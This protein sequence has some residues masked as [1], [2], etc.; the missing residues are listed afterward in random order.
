MNNERRSRERWDENPPLSIQDLLGIVRRR[1]KYFFVPFVLV[2]SASIL[3]VLRLQPIYRSSGK[4]FVE[5]QQIPQD[6]VR[7]M[8]TGFA[9][10]RI[11]AILQFVMTH[12]NLEAVIAKFGLYKESVESIADKVDW[13]REAAIVETINTGR[14]RSRNAVA[15]EVAFEHEEPE[16][17]QGVAKELVDLF[18]TE[19]A[20][21]RA[22]RAKEATE[23]LTQEMERLRTSMESIG[24]KIA[25]YKKEHYNSLPENLQL[26]A[27]KLNR[28]SERLR[29]VEREQEATLE[30]L[31]FY[32]I[33]LSAVRSG[34]EHNAG[35]NDDFVTPA[36]R[37]MELQNELIS[38]EAAFQPE[39]PDI[40]NLRR[41]IA[42]FQAKIISSGG[43]SDVELALIQ[44]RSELQR[45]RS[46][47]TDKHP[48]VK[49]QRLLIA[50]LENRLAK[51]SGD[52]R[53]VVLGPAERELLAQIRAAEARVKS[54]DEEKSLL[55]KEIESLETRIMRTSQIEQGFLALRRDYENAST[56]YQDVKGKQLE[57]QLAQNLEEEQKAERFT[58]LE[59]P[60]LPESPIR[61]DRRKL[62][63]MCLILSGGVGGG[64]VFL[65][66]WADKSV[67]NPQQV[68]RVLGEPPIVML[69]YIETAEDI[70]R[71]A[72]TRRYLIGSAA[73][74]FVILLVSVHYFYKPLDVL[75]EVLIKKIGLG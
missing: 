27:E 39:H 19:N 46:I 5:S 69:P 53:N 11:Q 43:R 68:A 72:A 66:E 42:A 25:D 2:L 65:L 67:R 33:Q 45:L 15:F 49:T 4:I 29:T 73:G 74:G 54:Y 44:V 62:L 47:Y 13:L 10:E 12:E 9:E 71:R 37:L 50:D 14:R 26:N 23:F 70:S 63:L 3:V 55:Q 59:A 36:E 18:L 17:A 51:L 24:Q 22:L 57:A 7:S 56:K 64:L 60:M 32:Q 58:L 48:D 75:S 28:A 40:M 6:I 16:V 1:W 30:Q 34:A 61:P 31:D 41:Q 21:A 35:K 52:I 8:V 38:K 20:E